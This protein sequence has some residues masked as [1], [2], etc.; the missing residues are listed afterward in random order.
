MKLILGR[1]S[2]GK[3]WLSDVLSDKYTDC[4]K[5]PAIKNGQITSEVVD[6]NGDFVT[7]TYECNKGFKLVGSPQIICDVDSD[8]WDRD[9]PKCEESK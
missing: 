6:E 4:E 2:I 7:A 9:P 5:P 3:L 8:E 1:F